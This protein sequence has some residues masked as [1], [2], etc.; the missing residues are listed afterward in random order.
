MNFC[1]GKL[2]YFYVIVFNIFSIIIKFKV[3][4]SCIL[5]YILYVLEI[6]FYKIVFFLVLCSFMSYVLKI[7]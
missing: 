1:N 3:I 7:I 2:E 4:C 5:N 6:I